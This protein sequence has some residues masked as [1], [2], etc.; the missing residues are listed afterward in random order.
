MRRPPL[1]AVMIA[2][3][4]GGAAPAVRAQEPAIDPDA[5]D[6]V[7]LLNGN[8][9]DGEAIG[10]SRGKLQFD[11][12]AMNVVSID[13]SD[14]SLLRSASIFEITDVTGQLYYG[15]LSFREDRPRVL[16]VTLGEEV[17]N[18]PFS[19]VVELRSLEE[20]F[21]AKT[22]GFIDVGINLARAND[23]QSSLLKGQ[24]R[25][26]GRIW[27]LD[28]NAESYFQSQLSD[29]SDPTASSTSRTSRNSITLE[30]RRNISGL[31]AATTSGRGES[32][33]ELS[34]DSRVLLTVGAR[35]SIIRNQELE[36]HAGASGVFNAEQFTGQDRVESGEAKF[37]LG[38]DMFDLGD[39]DIYTLGETYITRSFERYRLNLDT[40]ISWEIFND[41]TIGASA[42]ERFDSAPGEGAAKRDFQYGLTV[43]WTWG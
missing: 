10:M 32:N 43:G 30:G 39:V 21:W 11:T 13:W 20:S 23:L 31:W 18:L 33:E 28:L 4:H 5:P 14:I 19:V 26:G 27:E 41:F 9:L 25:Y 2:V 16:V 22:S 12:D 35:Y 42:V 17:V 36:L 3:A 29:G 8:A 40:R 15:D 37:T 34:L 38:F 1:I 7:V 24:F 6:R